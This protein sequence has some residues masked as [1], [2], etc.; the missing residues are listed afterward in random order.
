MTGTAHSETCCF[1]S[2]A[3]SQLQELIKKEKLG[4]VDEFSADLEKYRNSK[5]WIM[6]EDKFK[7][8]CRIVSLGLDVWASACVDFVLFEQ[9]QVEGSTSSTNTSM[10]ELGGFLNTFYHAL[11]L[12]GGDELMDIVKQL[13][14]AVSPVNRKEFAV[15]Y[16]FLPACFEEYFRSK[17][18]RFWAFVSGETIEE[19]GQLASPTVRRSPRKHSSSAKPAHS[20]RPGRAKKPVFAYCEVAEDEASDL[21]DEMKD[22]GEFEGTLNQCIDQQS[23]TPNNTLA[24]SFSQVDLHTLSSASIGNEGSNLK[25]YDD[26][27]MDLPPVL[28]HS[29]SMKFFPHEKQ[30]PFSHHPQH[31]QLKEAA[32]LHDYSL[33]QPS[34]SAVSVKLQ[35]IHICLFLL[36]KKSLLHCYQ[37]G[38][39]FFVVGPAAS[40]DSAFW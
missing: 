9:K 21:E 27:V 35:V 23:S 8:C 3:I 7:T 15:S 10:A 16:C 20:P 28:A 13:T 32:I 22:G 30:V 26:I 40:W 11:S 31:Q 12:K 4:N 17:L 34:E 1:G 2:P 25:R 39:Q 36:H 14:A 33:P 24:A 19:D 18:P 5:A 38:C 6:G 37:T 29:W